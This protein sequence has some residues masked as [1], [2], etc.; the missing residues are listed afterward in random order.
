MTISSE[1]GRGRARDDEWG[2][3]SGFDVKKTVWM[4]EA[5]VKQPKW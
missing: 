1:H 4:L 2:A 5:K 3:I